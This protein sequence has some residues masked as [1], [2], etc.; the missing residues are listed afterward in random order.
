MRKEIAAGTVA[1]L[2]LAAMLALAAPASATQARADQVSCGDV[3]TKDTTLNSDLDCG[4]LSGAFGLTIGADGVTLDLNGHTVSSACEA[5]CAATAVIDDRG[6]YDGVRILDGTIRPNGVAIGV[7][8]ADADT[9]AVEALTIA[10][11]PRPIE[12]PGVGILLSNSHRNKLDSST[13]AG[14]DPALLLSASD[15][16]EISRSSVDGGIAHHVG[17]GIRLADGSDNNRI[18]DS[19]AAGDGPGIVILDSVGNTVTRSRVGG[20]VGGIVGRDAHRNEISRNTF[21]ETF[22]SGLVIDMTSS[23]ENVIERNEAQGELRISGDRN[24]VEHNDVSGAIGATIDVSGGQANLVRKNMAMGGFDGIAV[25]FA[26]TDTLVQGNLATQ[27]RDDGI[28]VDA[29]GTIIRVNTAINNGDLGI[30]A[31]A[32]VIDGGGNRASGNGNPLQC[33]NVTCR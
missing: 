26:A 9:S 12:Q 29:P 4:G 17:D 31:V 11:F 19:V 15:G 14:G 3:I 28:D 25:E 33:T 2:S 5:D 21:D 23:D 20:I 1:T 24:R 13:I 6:G 7:A 27:A 18:V 10:G 30:E 8:L 16:N 32:G 22:L